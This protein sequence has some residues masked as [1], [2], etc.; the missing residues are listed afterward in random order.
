MVPVAGAGGGGGSIRIPAS[1]CGLVGLKPSRGRVSHGP[2]VGEGWGGLATN[3]VV[4][5]T[6]RDSAAV[7]DVLAGFEQ[8][9]PS[10]APALPGPLAREVGA[11]PGR[12]RVGFTAVHPHG[13]LPEDADLTAAVTGAA[14]LLES[15]GHR[16]EPGFPEALGDPDFPDR[17]FAIVCANL[18]AEVEGVGL[19]RGRPVAVEELEAFNRFVSERGRAIGAAEHILNMLWTDGYRARMVAWWTSFDLLLVP[20]L[21]VAPFRIGWHTADGVAAA[22]GRA[23]RTV[24]FTAPF[25]A[26]GQPAISL[27]LHR[28]AAGL[29]VGVQLVAAPGREDVL[30]RVAAQLESTFGTQDAG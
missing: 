24:A 21:G 20:T 1:L 13:G 15:L 5:R 6:V 29:P 7:L 2:V 12:L 8:G 9:D 17:F 18:V 26:T 19:W 11:D 23:I 25:N 10:T 3:G 22:L 27:P 14:G 28:T 4:T 30:I 16:V